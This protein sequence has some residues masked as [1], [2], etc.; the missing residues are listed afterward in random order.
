MAFSPVTDAIELSLPPD[1]DLVRLPLDGEAAPARAARLF[2]DADRG[3]LAFQWRVF[4]EVVDERH[5]LLERVKFLAI[6]GANLIALSRRTRLSSEARRLWTEAHAYWE[7]ELRPALARHGIAPPPVDPA[8]TAP[9]LV[10]L[11][12]ISQLDRPDLRDTPVCPRN[13]IVG[14]G[15][16]IFE[17]IR[18]RDVL[19]HHPYDAFRPVV[20]LIRQAAADPAVTSIAI[21]LYRTDRDSPIVL[22][23]LDALRRRKQVQAVVE[24]RARHDEENNARWAATLRQAGAHVTCGIVGLKV[25]AKLAVVERREAGTTRRYVHVSSG[26]YHTG[27]SQAY[28]D[29]ALLTCDDAI[30]SDAA[31]LFDFLG[32]R[33]DAPT[34]DR[35]LVAPFG[36]RRHLRGFIAREIDW[37]RAG[38]GGHIVMKMNAL[39]DREVIR[40]LYQASRAGVRIDLIVRGVCRLR[41][42]VP[43]LSEGVHVRSIV[44]RFL[45]HSR[46]WYFGNG[47]DARVYI[48]S[49]DLR[50]RNLDR[51]VEVMVPI[52]GRPLAHSIPP[53]ILEAYLADTV[54]ARVL[55]P[56]GRYVRLHP[57]PGE[58]TVSS[59]QAFLELAAG[60]V[61]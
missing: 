37:S 32:G 53:E 19:L 16:D 48:G 18:A 7:R 9:G 5:P 13:P 28:T 6:L 44:G 1:S 47:G 10:P 4:E 23:L 3:A 24:L 22:A 26:N 31:R 49:S 43:G 51:R 55:R 52:D 2:L 50:P 27:T 41:P 8:P 42:G 56:D 33:V 58:P 11:W 59:Q 40:Q 30:A 60:A 21:T 39:T 25:H 34:F 46:I 35:L 20:D 38:R 57:R 14:H 29:L 12:T 45:E 15:D 54:S 36:M 61:A 17:A